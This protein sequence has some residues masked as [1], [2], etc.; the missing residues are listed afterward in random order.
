MEIIR[1]QEVTKE[2]P[3]RTLFNI[4]RLNC[5]AG[6][7][8]GLVGENGSGKS[9][10]LR[11]LIGEDRDYTGKIEMRSDFAYV[12]QLKEATEKSGGQQV[13]EALQEAFSQKPSLLILDEPTANLDLVNLGWLIKVLK[14][15]RGTLLVVSHDRHFLNQVTSKTWFLEDKSVRVYPYAYDLALAQ[16]Q[17]EREGQA[18]DF[19]D[20]QAK[21]KQLEAALLLKK[22][23]A[24]KLTKKKKSVSSSDW[25][26]NSRLG[27]YDGK[28]KRMAQVAKSMEKRIV[29]ME[30]VKRPS[31]ESWAKIKPLSGQE[32]GERTLLRLKPGQLELGDRYLFAYPEWLIRVGEKIALTGANQSGKTSFARALLQKQLEGFYQ[33]TLKVAYFAQDMGQLDEERSAYDNVAATSG[34]DRVTIFN[35]LAM[36][37]IRYD[38]AQKKV[39]LLSGGER[40]RVQLARVLLADCNLLILDEPTNFLDIVAIEALE[41]GLRNYTG[42]VLLISHDQEFVRQVT[43]KSWTIQE[44]FLQESWES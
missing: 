18:R 37:N 4:D 44:G 17:R 39:G 26:V 7:K 5:L 36:L 3:E 14:A 9:S 27:S 21:V 10:L 12:P 22:E 20:Y 6:E 24:Q 19:Q 30:E 40:M 28:A 16:R 23:K 8:V 42:A 31:K 41:K 13:K 2:I 29:Q 11:L 38:K 43:Q 33:P 35:T 1:I 25:K 32:T 34:Q 15:Y